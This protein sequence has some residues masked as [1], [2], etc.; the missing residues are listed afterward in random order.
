MLG[1]MNIILRYFDV[2]FSPFVV[3]KSG[4][5]ILKFIFKHS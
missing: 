1:G 2:R 4:L 3:S 5:G